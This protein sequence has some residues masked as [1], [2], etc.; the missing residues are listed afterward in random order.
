MNNDK[1]MI[2]QYDDKTYEILRFDKIKEGDTYIGLDNIGG[3]V[4]DPYVTTAPCDWPDDYGS[5]ILKEIV[6]ENGK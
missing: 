1:K 3:E 2:V 5:F 6:K 4:S